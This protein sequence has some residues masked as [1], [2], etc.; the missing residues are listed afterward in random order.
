MA[1]FMFWNLESH[2]GILVKRLILDTQVLW[3]IYSGHLMKTAY[4]NVLLVIILLLDVLQI[5]VLN[6]V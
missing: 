2:S 1:L 5:N 6:T 3:K 4:V